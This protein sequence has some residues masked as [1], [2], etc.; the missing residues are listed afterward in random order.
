MESFKILKS[1]FK[2]SCLPH[3]DNS[4]LRC[5]LCAAY[6]FTPHILWGENCLKFHH[7]ARNRL[8][9]LMRKTAEKIIISQINTPSFLS[10]HNQFMDLNFACEL[11]PV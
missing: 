11:L 5:K 3:D 4:L 7:H 1:P 10:P 2:C 8:D 6:D 9:I